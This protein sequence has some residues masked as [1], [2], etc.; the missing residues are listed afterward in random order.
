MLAYGFYGA[1]LL[2]PFANSFSP[3]S[4]FFLILP[5]ITTFIVILLS[6]DTKEE[7][8]SILYINKNHL[9]NDLLIFIFISVFLT[10]ISLNYLSLSI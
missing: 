7:N 8:L 5:L 2:D 9:N 3:Y 6:E 1:G 10:S 4:I